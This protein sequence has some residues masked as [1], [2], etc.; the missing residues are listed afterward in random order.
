MACYGQPLMLGVWWDT[1]RSYDDETLRFLKFVIVDDCGT[2]PAEIP[3]DIKERVPVLLLRITEDI[4]WN[5]M[6]AR[7]LGMHHASGWCTMIDP[8]MVFSLPQMRLLIGATEGLVRGRIVKWALRHFN[9]GKID[10]SSPNTWLLHRDDF[11]AVG[12]YAEHY[13][14]AK[15][16]SDCTL[17]DVLRSVYKVDARP[18]LFADF[19]G[20]DAVADAMVTSLDRSTATNKKKRIKDMAAAKMMGG[21]AKWAKARI[22]VP[23]M[24]FP[25]IQVWPESTRSSSASSD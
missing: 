8:D 5:Q 6:A 15:G 24:N 17:Q 18:D 2:P 3:D 12:G 25:W 13:A 14:G 16:W 1:I 21:W 22:N 4:P 19:Y 7:N 20:T 10:Q 23:R 11:F 9:S